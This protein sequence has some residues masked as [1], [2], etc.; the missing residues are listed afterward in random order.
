[1]DNQK[2]VMIPRFALCAVLL[3]AICLSAAQS[4]VIRVSPTGSD[5]NNGSTWELAKKTIG[6][7]LY[8]AR[9]FPGDEIWVA[10]GTYNETVTLKDGVKLY[11]GFKGTETAVCERNIQVNKTI[12]KGGG[13]LSG[14]ITGRDRIG[15]TTEINGFT[16]ISTGDYGIFCNGIHPTIANNIIIGAVLGISCTYASP[17]IKN[18]VITGCGVGISCYEYSSPTITNNTI[19][20]CGNSGIC[21]SYGPWAQ[22][23]NN[24]IAFNAS[25]IKKSSGS[26]NPTIANN[27]VY[28]NKTNYIGLLAGET[29]IQQDPMLEC[30]TYGKFHIQSNSPCINKGDDS[31]SS[32]ILIDIDG[33]PRKLGEHVDIGAD[34]SDGTDWPAYVPTIIRVSPT[35]DDANDGSSWDKAKKTIQAAIDAASAV[36]GNVWVAKG[37]YNQD[38]TLRSNCYL[39]GGFTG[40]EAALAERD[41]Q[42]NETVIAGGH[43][44]VTARCGCSGSIDGFTIRGLARSAIYCQS[45]SPYI[46]NNTIVGGNSQAIDY[47]IYCACSSPSISNNRIT[48]NGGFGIYCESSSNASIANNTITGSKHSA[49]FCKSS[50][51][52]EI[53]HNTIVD[54]YGGINCEDSSPNII[55]NSIS[56]CSSGINCNRSTPS[57]F[58]NCISAC[59]DGISCSYSPSKITNNTVVGCGRYGIKVYDYDSRYLP[60]IT[61][62]IVVFNMEGVTC[63]GRPKLSHNC[64]YGNNIDYNGLPAGPTDICSDPMFCDKAGGD[65]HLL[66]TSPCIDA[67]DESA[68]TAGCLDI[69]NEPRAQGAAVDIGADE[70]KFRYRNYNISSARKMADGE[71]VLLGDSAFGEVAVSVVFPDCIYV[72]STS[73]SSGIRVEG[74]S[75]ELNQKVILTGVVAT[76]GNG[77][78][79]VRAH[80]IARQEEKYPIMPLGMPNKTVG[81]SD[82]ESGQRGVAGGVGLSNIGLLVRTWGK[83]IDV[84]EDFFLIKDGSMDAVLRV[85]C[86]PSQV[87]QKD[88]FISVTGIVSII[89]DE[90]GYHPMVLLTS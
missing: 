63:S 90:T 59:E 19:L 2:Q 10:A 51:S 38:L 79:L 1:M 44:A 73:R 83:V 75:A 8:S 70:F 78:R 74:A 89:K 29:D 57:I 65:F 3:F 23:K 18:N 76:N 6:E 27:C 12:I 35:G 67:G 87:A 36:G 9:S 84:G 80:N 82:I 50:S 37:T 39:Y 52:A 72:E 48:W 49:V 15:P 31:A 61:N 62:N 34:E 5:S 4:A 88:A 64:V 85:Q 11:G 24:I 45:S 17:T 22:I 47:G 30:A 16:I 42:A 28:G 13:S 41:I 77:E 54:C 33:G 66:S 43:D 71:A 60:T 53:C 32:S 69:D 7:A 40:T 25:G 81:G 20:G 58:N 14:T 46:N 56:R 55:S 86:H 21:G 26:N 68:T